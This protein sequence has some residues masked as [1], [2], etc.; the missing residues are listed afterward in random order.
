VV[1]RKVH[2]NKILRDLREDNIIH[3]IKEFV[4]KNMRG[5]GFKWKSCQSSR[6]M[7]VEKPDIAAWRR[8][9]L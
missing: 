2:N 5:I 3:C 9:Y 7:L 4:L 8:R 6:R 1:H